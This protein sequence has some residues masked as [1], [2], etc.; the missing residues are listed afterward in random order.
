MIAPHG[1]DG[2]LIDELAGFRGAVGARRELLPLD[3][4]ARSIDDA[5][6][7]RRDFGADAF[8]GNDRYFVPHGC[9]VLYAKAIFLSKASEA[10][11]LDKE[12]SLVRVKWGSVIIGM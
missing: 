8:A 3:L 7:G 10:G 9:I 5:T 1:V 2:G 12:P 6:G 11:L 4:H